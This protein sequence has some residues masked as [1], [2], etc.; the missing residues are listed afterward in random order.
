MGDKLIESILNGTADERD[1]AARQIC[2]SRIVALV[3]RLA[4]YIHKASPAG[5]E[6]IAIIFGVLKTKESTRMLNELSKKDPEAN[7]RIAALISKQYAGKAT[8]DHIL[9]EIRKFHKEEVSDKPETETEKVAPDTQVKKENLSSPRIHRISESIED[10]VKGDH[11]K[12]STILKPLIRRKTIFYVAAVILLVIAGVYIKGAF[13]DGEDSLSGTTSGSR[14]VARIIIE[15][16]AEME[17]FKS[18]SLNPDNPASTYPMTREIRT[19]T[20]DTYGS[21]FERVYGNIIGTD[22]GLN[23]LGASLR[24]VNFGNSRIQNEV[25]LMDQETYGELLLFPNLAALNLVLQVEDG[26]LAYHTLNNS[27]PDLE[28]TVR[29]DNVVVR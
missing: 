10:T 11:K 23:T 3:E 9:S 16:I 13:L 27:D 7:V 25:D 5:R 29:I 15:R 18:T 4:E 12:E 21:L 6:T 22:V 1:A 26:S 2:Q 14:S 19:V 24:H 20:G 8:F 17:K 28:I